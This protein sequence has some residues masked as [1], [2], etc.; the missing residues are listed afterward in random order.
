MWKYIIGI[1]LAL[2]VV[3]GM[4]YWAYR[5]GVKSADVAVAQYEGRVN[6]LNRQLAERSAQITERVVTNYVTRRETVREVVYRNRDV[7]RSAV[8]EQHRLSEGW[9][10]AHDQ[11][12]RILPIDFT[13]ASN[14]A[15]SDVSDRAALERISSNYGLV[16]EELDRFE[17]LQTF[18]RESQ[19]AQDEINRDND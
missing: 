16:E 5:T 12:V 19:R 11:S 13:L 17:A 6:E 7:L 4:G 18:I 14:P 10:Y 9:V 3:A 2:S 15:P 8:P 1:V